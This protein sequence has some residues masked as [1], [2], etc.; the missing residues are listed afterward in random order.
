M[1]KCILLACYW[2]NTNLKMPY[3]TDDKRINACYSTD[4][5]QVP[6]TYS[7]IIGRMKNRVLPNNLNVNSGC[8]N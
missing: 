4:D 1:S 7:L 2:S 8:L 3:S 6:N 5:K